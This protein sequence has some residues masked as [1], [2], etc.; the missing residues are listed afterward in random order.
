MEKIEIKLK[1]KFPFV[2]LHKR[3]EY[4]AERIA[5]RYNEVISLYPII[6]LISLFKGKLSGE[7]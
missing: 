4:I 7:I 5:R 6:I 2:Y 3:E 1:K